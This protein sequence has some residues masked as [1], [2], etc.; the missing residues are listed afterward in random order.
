MYFREE[1]N[2]AEESHVHKMDEYEG[3]METDFHITLI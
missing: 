1:V 3:L 2:E